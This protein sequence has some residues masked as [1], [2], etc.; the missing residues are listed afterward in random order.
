MIKTA[1]H[2]GEME[3]VYAWAGQV[4]GLIHDIPTEEELLLRII[5]EAEEIRKHGKNIF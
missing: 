1:I 3:Q 5:S 4:M 2:K